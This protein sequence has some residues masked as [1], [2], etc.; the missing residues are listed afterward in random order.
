MSKAYDSVNFTL[1]KHSLSCLA[2]SLSI[3]NILSDLLTDHHNQV[4]TNLGLTPSYHI[5]NSINQDEHWSKFFNIKGRYLE[6]SLVKHQ[7][8]NIRISYRKYK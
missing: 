5:Y 4:I 2:L 6:D 8:I 3:I 1:F 7:K